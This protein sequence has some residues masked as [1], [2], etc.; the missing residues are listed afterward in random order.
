MKHGLLALAAILVLAIGVPASAQYM[1]IDVNGDGANTSADVLGPA[2]TGV[3]V[4]LITNKNLSNPLDYDSPLVDATCIDG[5]AFTINSYQIILTAPSG[6]VTYGAWTDNMGFSIDVGN[7][8]AGN[9]DVVGWAGVT[10]LTP[11]TYKLGH[12]ALT[13]S[14]SPTL[15]FAQSTSALGTAVTAFGSI[16]GGSQFDNTLYLGIDWFSIG[17]TR[18][19]IPVTET[20]WGKIKSLYNH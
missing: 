15:T 16:C 13:V 9:D 20:T 12:L 4:W 6:G 18:S 19:T 11:G 1:Y 2:T 8:Q 14:G 10:P 17:P 7:V 5:G 3:D